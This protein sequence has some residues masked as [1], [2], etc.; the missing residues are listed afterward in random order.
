MNE[1]KEGKRQGRVANV[2]HR[3]LERGGLLLGLV[4]LVLLLFVLEHIVHAHLDEKGA[5]VGKE[6]GVSP[7]RGV[8]G[9]QPPP[10]HLPWAHLVLLVLGADVVHLLLGGRQ[11]AGLAVNVQLQPP[12][13]ELVGHVGLAMRGLGVGQQ[14]VQFLHLGLQRVHV[15]PLLGQLRGGEGGGGEGA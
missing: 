4:G 1:A 6:D 12:Q 15:V 11:L 14:V 7:G 10:S 2:T 9:W 13:L 5:M 3:L 8:P